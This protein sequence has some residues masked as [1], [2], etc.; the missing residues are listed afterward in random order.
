MRTSRPA[1]SWGDNLAMIRRRHPTW[2]ISWCTNLETPF[3]RAEADTRRE[4]M[5]VI[6]FEP[7]SW[8]AMSHGNL[9][10]WHQALCDVVGSMRHVPELRGVTRGNFS[11]TP[12][13]VRALIKSQGGEGAGAV[14]S[15]APTNRETTL[16]P[17]LSRVI[18]LRRLR[19]APFVCTLVPMWPFS[20]FSWPSSPRVHMQGCSVGGSM[21]LRV[22]WRESAE[23]PED[24]FA[25]ISWCVTWT[26][27]VHDGRKLEV[28]VDGLLL[29]GG[30]PIGHRHDDSVSSRWQGIPCHFQAHVS[31]LLLL[32]QVWCLSL[33]V[34]FFATGGHCQIQSSMIPQNVDI[35][36][37]T[38]SS[39][40]HVYDARASGRTLQKSKDKAS[41]KTMVTNFPAGTRR[42][43]SGSVSHPSDSL[44]A[45][46]RA[47]G[48]LSI[49]GP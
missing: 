27:D 14:L 39:N 4:L 16:S 7:P 11:H 21:L 6:G 42:L 18:L 37:S 19:Q 48:C 49:V 34:P 32:H 8:Q 3:L 26:P 45:R 38:L 31:S 12:A 5:G 40:S 25:P 10:T 24:A 41:F 36:A 20:R 1:A 23:K 15:V 35:K 22:F 28:V 43:H 13:Q 44:S 17:H 33:V 29:R 30:G 9:R 46:I 47:F 2:R